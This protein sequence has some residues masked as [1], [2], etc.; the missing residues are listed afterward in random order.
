MKKRYYFLGISTLI[1]ASMLL[2]RYESFHPG[3]GKH[4][5]ALGDRFPD[6]RGEL[7]SRGKLRVPADLQGEV[8][9]LIPV[10][11]QRSQAIVDSW[12]ADLFPG[13]ESRPGLRILEMP[14]IRNWNWASG[15]IDNAMRSGIPEDL[16][17]NVMTY[18][19]KMRPYHE[20]FGTRD[21][22]DVHVYVLDQ[23]GKIRFIESG[24]ASPDKIARLWLCVDRLLPPSSF[25]SSSTPAEGR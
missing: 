14:M 23:Q 25:P 18:Y 5:L 1:I 8:A 15:W 16:H 7:L 9:V 6:V 22:E 13:M 11:V 10:F 20:F 21:R 4:Q 24:V 19:G 17:D 12:T 2:I 3:T